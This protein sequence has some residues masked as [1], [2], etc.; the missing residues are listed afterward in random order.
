MPASRVNRN[1]PAGI[2][3]ARRVGCR[4]ESCPTA[5]CP[6]P[7]RIRRSARRVPSAAKNTSGYSS[8]QWKN[9]CALAI[10]FRGAQIL[11]GQLRG[12][13]S[14]ARQGSRPTTRRT[15]ARAPGRRPSQDAHHRS[16]IRPPSPQSP[17]RGHSSPRTPVP[18]R[19][20][21][22]GCR[23]APTPSRSARAT[24]RAGHRGR[25]T[26]RTATALGHPPSRVAAGVRPAPGRVPRAMRRA[27]CCPPAADD[28]ES[29]SGRSPASVVSQSDSRA[30]CTAIGFRSTP[31]R[32]R[33]AT[34]LRIAARSLSPM[35]LAWQPP[36]RTSAAS[37]AAAR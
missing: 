21:A 30:S 13:R 11:A 18:S 6:A 12:E 1:T 35:S 23:W 9:R 31:Y 4:R 22:P 33:S 32:Q 36:V 8:S 3:I 25:S 27:G 5:G 7:R 17:L 28:R 37:Y 26:R 16:A 29:S 20:P 15:P 19:E 10:S 24:P 34:L 14:S 2:V